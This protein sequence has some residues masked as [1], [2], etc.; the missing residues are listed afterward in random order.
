MEKKE[1]SQTAVT[2]S[3]LSRK[4]VRKKT[5]RY[6][7]SDNVLKFNFIYHLKKLPYND[8]LIAKKVI[9]VKLGIEE[10]TMMK[11]FNIRVNDSTS[12]GRPVD[13]PT[14]IFLGLCRYFKISAEEAINFEIP[15]ID[16]RE[17]NLERMNSTIIPKLVKQ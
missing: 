13:I 2:D 11:Y 1:N 16:I 4:K 15:I 5:K 3:T 10:K 7:S 17:K 6:K 14:T 12:S 9:P 8:Y